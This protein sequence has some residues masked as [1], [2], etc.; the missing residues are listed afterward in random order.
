MEFI[1]TTLAV[2]DMEE[3]LAFYSGV[4]GLPVRSRFRSGDGAEIVFL[5][6]AS[7]AAV[8]LIQRGLLP[9]RPR[10]AGI[11]LGF[12]ADSLEQAMMELA[13]AGVPV[14]RGPVAVGGGTRFFHVLDPDGYEIQIVEQPRH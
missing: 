7:G 13:N 10:G 8:E 4:L 5:G 6:S 1:W 14:V 12:K 11:S 9:E 3:S 2:S